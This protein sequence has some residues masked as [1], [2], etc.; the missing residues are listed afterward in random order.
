MLFR[1][2]NRGALESMPDLTLLLYSRP[3]CHLCETAKE[4]L[5]PLVTRYAL[6]VEERNVE[7]NPRW[8]RDYGMEIPVGVL[9]GRKVF[10]FRL[11]SGR[12]ERSIRASLDAPQRP[13]TDTT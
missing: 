11:D 1:S 4:G 13:R 2:L 3:G 5:A 10:K 12:L 9:A 8:E 7:D 6:R